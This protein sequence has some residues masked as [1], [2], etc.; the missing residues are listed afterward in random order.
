MEEKE[1]RTA[2][3][4]GVLSNPVRYMMYRE[5]GRQGEVSSRTLADQYNKSH[6]TISDH[7]TLMRKEDL[8]WNYRDGHTSLYQIKREDIYEHIVEFEELL[9]RTDKEEN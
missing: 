6:S 8:L 1:H 4:L 2:E 9:H 3:V 5:I 7:L